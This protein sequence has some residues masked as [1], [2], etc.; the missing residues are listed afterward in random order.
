MKF[1]AGYRFALESE[2]KSNRNEFRNNS[3]ALT[4][5]LSGSYFEIAFW[6]FFMK[7]DGRILDPETI[8]KVITDS[9]PL[10]ENFAL[11]KRFT[12]GH[13]NFSD[14]NEITFSIHHPEYTGLTGNWKT[15]VAQ[16]T[17]TCLAAYW[18][19]KAHNEEYLAIAP[20]EPY[21]NST[22]A[23]STIAEVKKQGTAYNIKA[24]EQY[25]ITVTEKC[26]P[27]YKFRKN[28]SNSRLRFLKQL[29]DD[30][31]LGIEYNKNWVAKSVKS[32]LF[33]FPEDFTLILMHKE[34]DPKSK[35]GYINDYFTLED[36]NIISLGIAGNPFFYSPAF[37][38]AAFEIQTML[39][40]PAV[41][42]TSIMYRKPIVSFIK[43]DNGF[44]EVKYDQL[45]GELMKKY[46]YFYLHIL[47]VTASSYIEYIEASIVKTLK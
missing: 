30:Y 16:L 36:E 7:E 39:K 46:L 37:P 43:D 35:P 24:W 19:E 34:Y 8:K 47:S 27:G 13:G 20:F 17:D 9:V 28:K 41:T 6:R 26:F 32:L 4:E 29:T 31:F 2:L 15:Q 10:L 5:K 3:L 45:H 40:D 25:V 1:D 21:I 33:E 44:T 38:P 18:N 42:T 12:N 23:S 11:R 22:I 14:E